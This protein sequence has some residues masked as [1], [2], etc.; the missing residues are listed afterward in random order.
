MIDDE[1]LTALIRVSL[2]D[3]QIQI[4]D[5]TGTRDH[6]RVRIRSDHFSGKSLLDQHRMV[7]RA[8]QTARDDGRIHALELRTEP[9]TP[10]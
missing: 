3:A 5:T 6:F 7:Y 8:V 10:R 4:V 2:P 1:S 9:L